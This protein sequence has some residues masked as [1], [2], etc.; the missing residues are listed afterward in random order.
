MKV[1]IMEVESENP[2][3]S[4]GMMSSSTEVQGLHMQSAGAL[5]TSWNKG[6]TWG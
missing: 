6:N 4:E 5:V 1:F 2:A 3:N